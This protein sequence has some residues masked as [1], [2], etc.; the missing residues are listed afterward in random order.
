MDRPLRVCFWTTSFG[1][2]Q[3]ALAWDL[4][5]RDDVEVRVAVSAPAAVVREP[6]LTRRPLRHPLLDKKLAGMWA[7]RRF[8]PDV[9][10][11]DNGV[12]WLPLAPAG[13]VHWHGYGWKGP[14]DVPEMRHRYLS[15][16]VHWGSPLRPTAR[17]RWA[18]F[19]PQDLEHRTRVGRLHPFLCRSIGATSHDLLRQQ[20]DRDQLQA[21]YPVD[22][23]GRPNLLVAPTWHYEGVLGH[24]GDEEVLLD[25]LV[26]RVRRHGGN[27]I[28]RLHD[29]WRMSEAVLS[30]VERLAHRWDNVVLKYKNEHPDG[31]TD[32]LVADALVTNM[33]SIANLF[34]ATRRPTIHVFPVDDEAAPFEWRRLSVGG[35]RTDRVES[36]REIWKLRPEINGG[37]MAH[38]QPELLE[39]ID[40]ALEDPSCCEERAAAFL[41]EYMLGADGEVC[42]R[43]YGCLQ[44]LASVRV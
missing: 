10:V 36:V 25:E 34:Y 17:L 9:V 30:I 38:D 2:D 3:L 24:W 29:R 28:F 1:P 37:L 40:R 8:A 26:R 19:G 12:P 4:D 44:E 21:A 6:S 32:L 43:A 23:V 14:N 33:S 18:C 15:L 39:L 16:A 42:E 41:D 27:V 22:V 20:V 7:L 13:F 11:V 31:L 35:V 5:E